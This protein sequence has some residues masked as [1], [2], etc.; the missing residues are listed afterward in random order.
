[1]AIKMKKINSPFR[2][3]LT[4]GKQ[5][6]IWLFVSA[7]FSL[8]DVVVSMLI[9]I[10]YQKLADILSF[11]NTVEK[12]YT[13]LWFV[14]ILLL[15][16]TLNI[17][18]RQLSTSRF[19]QYTIRNLRNK[20]AEHIQNLYFPYFNKHHSG[21]L[22][23][24]VND[25]IELVKN[26]L[27][28]ISNF[29]YQP[30]IFIC[31]I[32]YGLI[33][34]PKLLLVTITVLIFAI[35]LNNIASKPI[36]KFSAKLQKQ[37]GKTISMIQDTVNG[38][39][40]V[41]SFNLEKKLQNSYKLYQ[42]HVYHTEMKIVKRRLYTMILSTSVLM[43][44]MIVINLYG[45][46]LTFIGEMTIG[47]FTAFLAI[48]TYLSNPVIEVV[49]LVSNV[50]LAKGGAERIYEILTYPTEEA[51]ENKDTFEIKNNISVEFKNVSFSYDG[52]NSTLKDIDF[53][54]FKNKAIASIGA[55][56][57]GKSTILGLL[58]G[59]YKATEGNI[60][61]FGNAINEIDLKAL[62][63]QISMVTQN[64]YIY[65]TTVAENIS[66]GKR[67]S[68]RDEI[69]HAAKMA[70]AHDFI[71]ELPNGYDTVLGGIGLIYQE[72]KNSA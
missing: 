62:R 40:I 36:S 8:F 13:Y 1:M 68:R 48:I 58:F 38:I 43:I 64:T 46:R 28:Q 12:F 57:G 60:K 52:Q 21:D 69:I 19:T 37:L 17:F 56:G 59:F 70:N 67:N 72:D 6:K 44:P 4:F 2:Y 34:S 63:S 29:V 45:G 22:A 47:K 53:K 61:V 65:P 50:K 14:V 39:Y 66:Y 15:M 5:H 23:S 9:P 54:L 49:N 24:R 35:G 42:E 27:I 20:I 55:S 3:I 31:S 30:L 16:S 18:L 71:M 32:I 26:L 7:I 11:D 51:Y 10:I 25:D 33:L 41:K